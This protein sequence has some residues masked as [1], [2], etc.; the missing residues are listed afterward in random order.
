MFNFFEKILLDLFLLAIS[1][2]YNCSSL[3][4]DQVYLGPASIFHVPFVYRST[5]SSSPFLEEND[6]SNVHYLLKC[7]QITVDANS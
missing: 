2:I 3:S 1:D 7:Q 5:N 4:A 6:A